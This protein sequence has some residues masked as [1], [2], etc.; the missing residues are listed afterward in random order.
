[1]STDD[2][3]RHKLNLLGPDSLNELDRW[4]MADAEREE[5]RAQARQQRQQEQARQERQLA[6]AAASEQIAALRAELATLRAEHESL[7]DSV[8]NVMDVIADTFNTLAGQRMDLSA[9]QREEIRALKIE[10]AKVGS[11]MDQLP[12]RDF[13]FARERDD[14]GIVDLP[15]PLPR[16]SVN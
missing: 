4:R 1:M 10:V 11:T 8:A 2:S 7:R 15:N 13:K 14:S 5:A 6:R 16:R 3:W 9:E 12:G